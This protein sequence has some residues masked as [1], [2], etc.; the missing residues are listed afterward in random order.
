MCVLFDYI[1][2]IY[3]LNLLFTRTM[4]IIVKDDYRCMRA[5]HYMTYHG[6]S[7]V[8]MLFSSNK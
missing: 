8:I 3:N 5:I 2:F 4:K 1:L 7:Y 6:Y